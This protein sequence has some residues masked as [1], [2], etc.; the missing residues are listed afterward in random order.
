MTSLKCMICG[1]LNNLNSW[2]CSH[3]GC[4]IHYDVCD[5]CEEN[6]HNGFDTLRHAMHV[7]RCI[8]G[9]RASFTCDEHAVPDMFDEEVDHRF[10]LDM[11]DALGVVQFIH[12]GVLNTMGSYVLHHNEQTHPPIPEQA[13][14][15][16]DEPW[17]PDESRDDI[18]WGYQTS[19]IQETSP[20][21]H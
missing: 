10:D 5:H 12:L 8:W 1:D 18:P 11:N 2:V 7:G 3:L 14:V 6:S 16:H 21:Q 20:V 13:I 15:S 4:R 9:F 17:S 19:D